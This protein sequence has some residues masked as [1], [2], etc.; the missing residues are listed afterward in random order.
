MAGAADRQAALAEERGQA[1]LVALQ[2]ADEAGLS[3]LEAQ[4]RAGIPERAVRRALARLEA[5]GQARRDGSRWYVVAPAGEPVGTPG[6]VL[7]PDVDACLA[8]IPSEPHRAFTRLLLA[9]VASRWHLSRTLPTGWPHFAAFGEPRQG[10]TSIAYLVATAFDL[11]TDKTAGAEVSCVHN[12]L[13]ETAKSLFGRRRME[14]G[15]MTVEPAPELALP[16]VL[17]DECDKPTGAYLDELLAVLDG[18]AVVRIERTELQ[19]R[20]TPM[21]AFNVAPE[22]PLPGWYHAAYQARAVMLDT[23][24]VGLTPQDWIP[25]LSQLLPEVGRSPL[26][27]IDLRH[28]RVNAG[29]IDE[30]QAVL[31]AALARWLTRERALLADARFLAR[32]V[33]GWCAL[34]GQSAQVAAL[35]VAHDYL[36]CT[37]TTPGAVRPGYQAAIAAALAG[38]PGSVEPPAVEVEEEP[39]AAEEPEGV[40]FAELVAAWLAGWDDG[41]GDGIGGPQRPSQKDAARHVRLLVKLPAAAAEARR[42]DDEDRS[43][44]Y[45]A[46]AEAGGRKAE[47][48]AAE[49]AHERDIAARWEFVRQAKAR[50]GADIAAMSGDGR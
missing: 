14:H 37:A 11:P 48:L 9:C 43:A 13:R 33:P 34:S 47:A 24:T 28:L 38:L 31:T 40:G 32:I 39:E 45:A 50:F 46:G 4:D 36:T 27:R 5:R 16:F 18:G 2:G 12:V 19:V 20:F 23:R 15:R 44:A 6:P 29:G 22:A 42:Y 8:I 17:L 1:L 10:K 21:V 3:A 25:R 35:H 30:A 49:E 7:R 41:C 26:P